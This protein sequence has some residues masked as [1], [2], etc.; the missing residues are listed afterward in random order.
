MMIDPND[1][2]NQKKIDTKDKEVELNH[3]H[4]VSSSDPESED[5]IIH[6]SDPEKNGK[7]KKL[8]RDNDRI[9]HLEKKSEEGK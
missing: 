9:V 5:C 7:F 8:S 4:E 3:D 2:K 1:E 6:I